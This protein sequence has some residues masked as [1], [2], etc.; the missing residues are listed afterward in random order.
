[1]PVI[2]SGTDVWRIG[3]DCADSK[4]D[5][6]A[7][8]LVFL[9]EIARGTDWM[10]AVW[11]WSHQERSSEAPGH[12]GCHG[13][14]KDT[15]NYKL[16]WQHQNFQQQGNQGRTSSCTRAAQGDS[17]PVRHGLGAACPQRV[18]RRQCHENDDDDKDGGAAAA[19]DDK[20]VLAQVLLPSCLVGF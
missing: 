8:F 6:Y 13:F 19:Q 18:R 11:E 5:L 2:W 12:R 1:M 4:W 20:W 14:A 15:G 17:E 16:G 3:K 10:M 9:Y 7:L